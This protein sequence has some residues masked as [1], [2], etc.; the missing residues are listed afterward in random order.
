MTTGRQPNCQG[1][2]DKVGLVVALLIACLWAFPSPS[3]AQLR[4][5]SCLLVSPESYPL[6]WG[7][8]SHLMRTGWRCRRV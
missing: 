3:V 5:Q 6:R 4:W 7:R 8:G 1:K 2:A